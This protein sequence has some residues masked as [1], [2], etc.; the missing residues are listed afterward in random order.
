[1]IG[2]ARFADGGS[3]LAGL[4]VDDPHVE[5][6]LGLRL[7]HRHADTGA[8]K[9]EDASGRL[10]GE[11]RDGSGYDAVN[12]CEPSQGDGRPRIDKPR[13]GQALFAG[14]ALELASFVNGEPSRLDQFRCQHVGDAAADGVVDGGAA[15]GVVLK[16]QDGDLH[17]RLGRRRGQKKQR[18]GEQQQGK[19][20]RSLCLQLK[21]QDSFGLF[22]HY[23]SEKPFFRLQKWRVT[24]TRGR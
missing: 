22:Y 7:S 15:G 9:G 8:E 17:L 3:H 21:P 14:D 13:R 4:D 6:D 18:Q 12:A 2:H 11:L 1:M 5:G 23:I 19:A 16:F 20:L 24:A 10:G